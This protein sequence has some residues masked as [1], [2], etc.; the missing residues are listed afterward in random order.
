[1]HAFIYP[2]T[3]NEFTTS[4]LEPYSASP[5]AVPGLELKRR[6]LVEKK[7]NRL[8]LIAGSNLNATLGVPKKKTWQL[9]SKHAIGMGGPKYPRS[10]DAKFHRLARR[11]PSRPVPTKCSHHES[12][13]M[14]I[15]VA[16]SMD[17]IPHERIAIGPAAPSFSRN[18]SPPSCVLTS[19]NPY[20]S[21]SMPRS[22]SRPHVA[23]H[24]LSRSPT[25][26]PHGPTNTS[27]AVVT[28]HRP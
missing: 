14:L 27:E 11:F 22:D 12:M 1:M 20:S 10:A 18:A 28:P 9:T 5:T 25:V 6:D 15:G 8:P 13:D 17:F 21:S 16:F 7:S 23:S 4:D 3:S 2:V 24:C 26:T 19:S